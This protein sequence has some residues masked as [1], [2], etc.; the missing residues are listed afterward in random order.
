MHMCYIC[1]HISNYVSL[2]VCYVCLCE[3][4]Y[5]GVCVEVKGCPLRVGSPLLPYGF[6]ESTSDHQAWWH[7]FY[8]LTGPRVKLLLKMTHTPRPHLSS[9]MN[10][11][12]MLIMKQVPICTRIHNIPLLTIGKG[13]SQIPTSSSF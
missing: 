7:V 3:C 10:S 13:I 12:P 5:H 11:F 9:E 8:P 2:F 4:A 6:Q 1:I